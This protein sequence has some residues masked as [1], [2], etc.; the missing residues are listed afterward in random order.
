MFYIPKQGDIIFLDFNP[1]AG[2]DQAG[3]RPG[4]IVSNDQFFLITKLAAVCPITNTGKEFPL[5]IP[6]DNRA[7]F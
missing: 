6:L 2:H 7:F 3:Q 5:H 1:Q 4:V